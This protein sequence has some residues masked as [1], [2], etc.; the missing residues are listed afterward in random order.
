MKRKRILNNSCN[1]RRNPLVLLPERMASLY[2]L[3]NFR[4]VHISYLFSASSP[5]YSIVS[6]DD[7]VSLFDEMREARKSIECCESRAVLC[8]VVNTQHVLM[9]ALITT[10]R[11]V[12][13]YGLL[14]LLYTHKRADH[15]KCH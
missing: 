11:V 2:T 13:V 15:H 9:C 7:A 10:G 3:N 12:L 14:E 8:T 6:V 1:S 4:N 5:T